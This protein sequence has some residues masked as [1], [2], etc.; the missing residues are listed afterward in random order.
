MGSLARNELIPSHELVLSGHYS[1]A[2]GAIMVDELTALDYLRRK[3]IHI[4]TT[5]R[6]WAVLV[7]RELVLGLVKILPNRINNY[8]PKEWRILNK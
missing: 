7:Y 2:F 3:D 6:G 4:D 8:Y 5:I 1:G